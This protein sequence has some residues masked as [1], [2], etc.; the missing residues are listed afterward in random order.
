MMD[1]AKHKM[2]NNETH[3]NQL[4]NEWMDV[5]RCERSGARCY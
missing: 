5:A 1:A 4:F 2:Q 3:N